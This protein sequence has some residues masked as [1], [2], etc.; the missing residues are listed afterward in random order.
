MAV[1]PHMR[2]EQFWTENSSVNRAGSS[3]HAW[4]TGPNLASFPSVFRFIPTCV[5]NSLCP[6]FP[7]RLRPV[8]P[9]MRGEQR[10]AVSFFAL[11]VGSS[12]H[13]WGTELS[14]LNPII[15]QRF[16][17]TCVGNSAW[18]PVLQVQLTVHPHMRGEQFIMRHFKRH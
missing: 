3:P 8:H 11:L 17:P 7:L 15:N 12:P 14:L 18:Q 5:G 6:I 2:G 4:G 16:I 13:A 9:H 10:I 1:H